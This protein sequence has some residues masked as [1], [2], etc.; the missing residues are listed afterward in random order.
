MRIWNTDTVY[1]GKRVYVAGAN[2]ITGEQWGIIPVF[3][4]DLDHARDSVVKDLLMKTHL[5]RDKPVQVDEPFI[6]ENLFG[7][8]YFSDGRAEVLSLEK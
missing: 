4:K 8:S 7:H 5:K 3:I 2:A 1:R 6:K